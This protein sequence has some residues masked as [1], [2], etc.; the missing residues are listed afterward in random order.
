MIA[1]PPIIIIGLGNVYRGDDRVGVIIAQK[2]KALNLSG[3]K[4]YDCMNDGS[5]LIETW[6]GAGR[7]YVVDCAVSGQKAGF[8]YRFDALTEKIPEKCFAHFST[9]AISVGDAVELAKTLGELPESLIVYGITGIN[10]EAGTEMTPEVN[11]A[12][13]EVIERILNEIAER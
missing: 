13:D 10:F 11:R 6:T 1:K 3:V 8:I 4:V 12:A 5:Q 2:I 9:H 7:V